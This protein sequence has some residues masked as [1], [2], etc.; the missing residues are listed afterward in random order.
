MHLARFIALACGFLYRATSGGIDLGTD[1][2]HGGVDAGAWLLGGRGSGISLCYLEVGRCARVAAADEG[3]FACGGL[4]LALGEGLFLLWRTLFLKPFADG[5][6]DEFL[7]GDVLLAAVVEELVELVEGK[8]DL[9]LAQEFVAGPLGNFL[10]SFFLGLP[11]REAGVIHLFVESVD[12]L[13]ER[14]PLVN[15]PLPEL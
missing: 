1:L 7:A 15:A 13:A 9:G 10:C 2:L 3:G 6:G 14:E 12:D 4:D 5:G 8:G 11:P